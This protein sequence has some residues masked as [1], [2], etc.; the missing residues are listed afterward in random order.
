MLNEEPFQNPSFL[1]L[2]GCRKTYSS[3]YNALLRATQ[4]GLRFTQPSNKPAAPHASVSRRFQEKQ[5]HNCSALR[6]TPD[7][8]RFTQWTDP[9]PK[10]SA[11]IKFKA[12]SN[13]YN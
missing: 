4:Q 11:T 12:N 7:E 13:K 6:D 5:L 3:I 1:S 2:H 8:L 9:K 10:F